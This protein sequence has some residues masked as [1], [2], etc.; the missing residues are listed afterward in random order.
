MKTAIIV[1][2]IALFAP[3]LIS[4]DTEITK[5][6]YSLIE[7]Y[8]THMVVGEWSAAIQVAETLIEMVPSSSEAKFYLIYAVKKTGAKYPAWV[9]KPSEWAYSTVNDRFYVELAKE[10]SNGS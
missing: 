5:Q 1:L 8:K 6:W 7:Q 10:I 9:G 3:N 4:A 2:L